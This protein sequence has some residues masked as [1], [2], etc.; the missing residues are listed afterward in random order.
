MFSRCM[1]GVL[2]SAG[3]AICWRPVVRL[4][5]SRTWV[6]RLTQSPELGFGFCLS[7]SWRGID[8][9]VFAFLAYAAVATVTRMLLCAVMQWFVNFSAHPEVMQP[10]G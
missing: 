8:L 3:A 6:R 7:S 2:G 5:E 9:V 1:L 10:H 4:L